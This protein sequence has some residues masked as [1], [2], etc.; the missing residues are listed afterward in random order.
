MKFFGTVTVFVCLTLAATIINARAQSVGSTAA[1]FGRFS[2]GGGFGRTYYG[3]PA[4]IARACA[5]YGKL[6][7]DGSR[8]CVPVV[9]RK[10]SR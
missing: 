10:V 3:S 2:A 6:Q 8:R 9:R 4:G 1:M 7:R 5:L